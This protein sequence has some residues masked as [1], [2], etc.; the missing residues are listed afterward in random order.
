MLQSR[1]HGCAAG[2]PSEEEEGGLRAIRGDPSSHRCSTATCY[3]ADQTLRMNG[4]FRN[5]AVL[6]GTDLRVSGNGQDQRSDVV[7]SH[8]WITSSWSAG[9][10]IA[11]SGVPVPRIIAR[12]APKCSSSTGSP[13]ASELSASAH[14][15]QKEVRDNGSSTQGGF[16]LKDDPPDLSSGS[17]TLPSRSRTLATIQLHTACRQARTLAVSICP[18]SEG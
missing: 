12:I 17:S 18:C 11:P 7:T 10:T 4:P 9:R 1:F 13:D 5:V 3:F 14:S 2:L 16:V 6:V 15:A 8:C